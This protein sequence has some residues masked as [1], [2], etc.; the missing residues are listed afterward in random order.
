M[1]IKYQS[2]PF[3][4]FKKQ[5]GGTLDIHELSFREKVKYLND[6][7][8]SKIVDKLF[9]QSNISIQKLNFS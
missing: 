3:L 6:Y 1:I 8:N 7:K 4:G 9:S 2:A 5:T